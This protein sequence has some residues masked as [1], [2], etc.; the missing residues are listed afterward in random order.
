MR[1]FT[2]KVVVI[3]G[4]GSGIG[5]GIVN[6]FAAEGAAL[7]LAG[8]DAARLADAASEVELERGVRALTITTD[9]RD[10]DA[11]QALADAA[12]AEFGAVHVVCN[13][14]GVSTL[15]SLWEQPLSDWQEVLGV[16]LYGVV[17]GI[18]SF[19]PRMLAGGQA[20]HVIN[21]S[22]MGGLTPTPQVGSYCA[23]KHAVVGLSKTLREELTAIGAPV[24]VTLVCPGGVKSKIMSGTAARYAP[25]S[26]PPAAQAVL[27][28]LTATVESGIT[29]DQAGQ[30]ILD[31]VRDDR[32]WAFPN[33]EAYFHLVE[34][35]QASMEAALAEQ[36]HAPHDG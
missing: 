10:P 21:V 6:A 16:N 23:S 15:G 32:F 33:G 9:V 3:T 25:G 4:A 36:A 31:A 22:S 17:H 24:G 7:I 18:R 19:L 30:I 2:G 34:E 8:I 28:R 11:V 12:Y 1:D 5:R 20:G 14:A 26:L 29:G 27:D 13:N 35:E